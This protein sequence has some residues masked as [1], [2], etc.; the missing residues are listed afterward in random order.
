LPNFT[1]SESGQHAAGQ[2]RRV[3]AWSFIASVILYLLILGL[4]NYRHVGHLDIVLLLVQYGPILA[5]LVWLLRSQ[6]DEAN[7]PSLPRVNT[8]AVAACFALVV[9]PLSWYSVR[10][11]LNSDESGYS[12]LARI[13][14][15]G[16]I[17][18]DPL[19]G[20]TEKVQDTPA[21][22]FYSNHVLRIYGW[23]PK[24]PAGWPLVLSV[25][26][27]ISARWLPNAV[28][29]T[30]QLLVI[31]GIG[32]RWF[33]RE[34]G[35]LAVVLAALSPFY[36]VNSIGMM[37][38]AL[39][40]LLCAAAC[41]ALSYALSTGKLSYYAAMFACLAATLQVRPYTGF[42]VTCI[43]TG[44][45]LWLS[46][47]NPQIL[48]RVLA[49]GAVFGAL[50]VT[51]VLFYN[52]TYSGHW[53]VSPYA[54]AVG[55]NLPPELSFSPSVILHGMKRHGPFMAL[56]TLLGAFPFLHLLAGYAVVKE[57]QHRREVWILAALYVGLVVAYLAHPL[58]YAVFFGERFHF[59]AFFALALLA[60]R[61]VQLFLEELR[62]AQTIVRLAF[63]VLCFLQICQIAS[64]IHGVSRLEEPYRKIRAAVSTPNVSGVVFLQDS[65]GFVAKH[66]NLNDA[67]WHHAPRIFLVDAEP[68]KRVEWACRYGFS[69]WYVATYDPQSHQARIN[70]GH[71]SCSSLLQ[72][73]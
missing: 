15:S 41:L 4:K 6:R 39:C 45:A 10:G 18:A 14:R 22:L 56:E 50:A 25:A 30:L 2:N 19:V 63:A 28:F 55:S 8:R 5:S 69:E 64:A 36:L 13:Y 59:D 52:R 54:E 58:G 70:E 48:I 66:F 60:A 24:F 3:A 72:H 32:F 40:S 1:Q 7:A 26:Y 34:V 20:A 73:P 65:P 38:H 49:I 37:S 31:A 17:M 71:G 44:A 16:R 23:F 57:K 43:L 33:S 62:S 11:L 47:S 35:G 68:D 61:G 67:D 42:V 21:E 29:G 12:F 51:G 9:L 27:R 46:R 53:M